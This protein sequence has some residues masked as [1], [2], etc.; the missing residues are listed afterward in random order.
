VSIPETPAIERAFAVAREAHRNQ[1]RKDGR[2]YIEHPTQVAQLL[3]DADAREELLVAAVLHDAVE[4]S[5]L[6]VDDLREEFG[7]RVAGLVESL[8]DNPELDTWQEK[9]DELRSRVAAAGRDAGTI[10]VADKIAN[11]RELVKLY[12]F[13]GESVGELEKAPT[14]DARVEAW[15]ADLAM[16]EE[17]GVYAGFL[18]YF[19]IQLDGLEAARNG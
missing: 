9:K 10:Y 15:R 4:D 2:P 16:A 13:R 7:G 3:A 5:D 17:I 8:T 1:Q 14:L 6:T 18:R 12:A 19:A 11:L